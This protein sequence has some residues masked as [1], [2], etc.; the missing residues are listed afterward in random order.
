VAAPLVGLAALEFALFYWSLNEPLP[1]AGNV[2]ATRL[3]RADLLWKALPGVVPGV[4]F[5]QSYLG[6]AWA[7]CATSRTS[8]SGCRSSWGRP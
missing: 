6:G 3:R 7:S 5:G 4:R 8:P 1:N 2:G